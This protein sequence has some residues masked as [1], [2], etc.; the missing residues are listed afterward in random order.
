MPDNKGSFSIIDVG[1]QKSERKK[2]IK[3]FDQVTAVIFVASLSCYDEV[4]FE[5][6]ST[7]S[8]TDQLQLFD[9]ICNNPSLAETSMILFLNKRDLFT[10]KIDHVPL[11][12][13]PSFKAYSGN[14]KSFDQ[15]TKYIRK[16]FTS[17]NNEPNRKN[18]FTHITC[19][20]DQDN[21]QKVFADV[22][23]IVIEASLIQAGLMDWEDN[24]RFVQ[25]ENNKN[26]NK[27]IPIDESQYDP[28]TA[29]IIRQTIQ[30]SQ[31]NKLMFSKS[32]GM[33]LSVNNK[34][35]HNG[36][37]GTDFREIIRKKSIP[38]IES[39]EYSTILAK[40]KY[41]IDSLLSF[42]DN[43]SYLNC[44]YC[45]AKSQSEIFMMFGIEPNIELMQK[46][47][48]VFLRKKLNLTIV[49]DIGRAMNNKWSDGKNK[50]QI[51]KECI[52]S[53]IKLL[54]DSDRF[55][56]IIFDMKSIVI[57]EIEEI[58]KININE[59]IDKIENEI[60]CQQQSL[61][62][63][64]VGSSGYKFAVSQYRKL[65]T[66]KKISFEYENR[67]IMITTSRL[68]EKTL[69]ECNQI[70]KND[71][72]GGKCVFSTFIGISNR[73][74]IQRT[75][76]SNIKGCNYFSIDSSEQL[77]DK[78]VTR[79]DEIV[80]PLIF[81]LNILLKSNQCKI[82]S[83]YRLN[84]DS[85]DEEY[86]YSIKRDKDKILN[87][88]T[89]FLKKRKYQNDDDEQNCI[90]H[91]YLFLIKLN[92]NN[93]N[94][95]N[96]NIQLSIQFEQENQENKSNQKNIIFECKN[97]NDY[98]DNNS[99]RKAILISRYVSILR[100]WIKYKKSNNISNQYQ[101]KLKQFINY[102]EKESNQL[103]DKE[104]NK[105]INVLQS[106]FQ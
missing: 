14:P 80:T 15:T 50:M 55:C 56:L 81:N 9:D 67:I 106:L 66:Q 83:I 89:L 94:N 95:N 23:H 10:T 20:T 79:F 22:Q 3:C 5:D 19:A 27:N 87:I 64:R 11:Q 61:D 68:S 28:E 29:R 34:K 60:E 73:F 90:N 59:L 40:Y 58:C 12:K 74:P 13:C 31:K 84:Y 37:I 16:A 32:G 77:K 1:G 42:N 86:K 17:L 44:K 51:T 57:Q 98:Y 91:K 52:I 103:S 85:Y 65:W 88:N 92:T 96:D 45:F 76:M 41:N 26:N 38:P 71:I 25:A 39:I 62:S 18:I 72:N 63:A 48:G 104:I 101:N 46:S 93:N 43:N 82:N 70:S 97:N 6:Y 69:N 33:H 78:F 49:L 99:I 102:F 105:E 24:Q 36:N 30:I 7:N 54:N 21:I 53:I 8:M 100:E 2:W 47:E 75:F 35:K 4:L